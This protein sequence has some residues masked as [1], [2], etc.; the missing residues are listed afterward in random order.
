M[1][2]IIN[3]QFQS[4]IRR[5]E[6]GGGSAVI[7]WVDVI[8]LTPKI[9]I[10]AACATART[11]VQTTIKSGREGD[12]WHQSRAL[13][14]VQTCR[15]QQNTSGKREIEYSKHGTVGVRI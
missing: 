11:T 13:D 2:Q 15:S 7:I 12:G 4:K 14:I 5:L 10:A 6:E 1:L 8:Q 3:I 9:G